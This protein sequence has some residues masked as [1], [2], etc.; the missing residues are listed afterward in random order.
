MCSSG[1][2]H[3]ELKKTDSLWGDTLCSRGGLGEVVRYVSASV[4]MEGQ[5]EH[6]LG[7]G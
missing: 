7:I 4:T 2:F 1:S 6:S 5:Q 3:D